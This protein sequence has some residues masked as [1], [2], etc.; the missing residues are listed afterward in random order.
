MKFK[1]LAIGQWF[2]TPQD[3]DQKIRYMKISPPIEDKF[4]NTIVAFNNCG[5]ALDDEDLPADC[6]VIPMDFD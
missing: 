3:E 5:F 6:E 4:G 1:E 2:K